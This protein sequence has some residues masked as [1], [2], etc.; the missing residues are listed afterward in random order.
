MVKIKGKCALLCSECEA[1]IAT[2]EG[3]AAKLK[4][5]AEK[6]TELYQHPF[7]PEDVQCD[8]CQTADGRLCSYAR[9]ACAIRACCLDK[10]IVNCYYCEHFACDILDKFFELVPQARQNLAE[11]E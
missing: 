7:T 8:G 3:D 1:Y 4:E 2:Q 9:S 10:R 11:K 6:W 5:V